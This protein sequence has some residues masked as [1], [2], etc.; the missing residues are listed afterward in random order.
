MPTTAPQLTGHTTLS[1]LVADGCSADEALTFFDTLPPVTTDDVTG[2][3]RG[4]EI[5]T[6]SP[7]D[8]LPDLA[9][10]HG[11]RIHSADS[12]H[13]L[14]MTGSHGRFSLNPALL[15]LRTPDGLV[16]LLRRQLTRSLTRRLLPMLATEQSTAVVRHIEYRGVVSAAVVY[17]ALPV[18]E[19]LR[20]V[21]RNTLVGA[22]DAAELPTPWF[23]TLYRQG[24]DGR[25]LPPVSS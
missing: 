24:A 4:A 25:D 8:G 2:S 7:M 12:A 13:P 10:W 23:F 1:S 18:T 11:V 16:P 5:T 17:D 22:L 15:P 6:G 14:I 21:D 20:A 9:G 3:W 19:Y